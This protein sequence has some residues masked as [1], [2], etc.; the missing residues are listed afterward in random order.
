M[1]KSI[2]TQS[3]LRRVL[4][5]VLGLTVLLAARSSA[6]SALLIPYPRE[7]GVIPASTY[8]DSGKRIGDASIELR[9]SDIGGLVLEVESGSQDGAGN[10]LSAE[11]EV[12]EVEGERR[13]RL[14]KERSQSFDPEGKPLV[15]LEID[16]RSGEASC[17]PSGKSRKHAKVVKLPQVDRVANV[18]LHLLFE[19]LVHREIDHLDVQVFFCLG[20]PRILNF[21]ATAKDLPQPEA[22]PGPGIRQVSYSAAGGSLISWV[23]K[24]IGPTI[25]FWFRDETPYPYMGHYLPLYSGGPEVYI[26]REGIEPSLVIRDPK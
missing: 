23:A 22:S 3:S 18:P 25:Y 15:L 12:I 5:L 14:L 20:G 1:A 7:L 17:T 11:L 19:P 10:K 9:K 8:D 2:L 13:L 4:L 6:E 24:H 16:H 26:I 21:R